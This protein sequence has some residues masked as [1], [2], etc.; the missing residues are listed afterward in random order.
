MQLPLHGSA[1]AACYAT[2]LGQRSEDP[3]TIG[4]NRADE[5]GAFREPAGAHRLTTGCATAALPA[6]RPRTPA[7]GARN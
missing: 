1:V 4:L 6:A 7:V 5:T 2:T 3:L